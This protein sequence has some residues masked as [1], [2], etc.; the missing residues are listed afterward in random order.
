MKNAIFLALVS[1]AAPVV[2]LNVKGVLEKNTVWE[3]SQNPIIVSGNVEIPESLC[4]QIRPGVIVKFDGYFRLLVR[5]SLEAGGKPGNAIEFVSNKETPAAEDWEGLVFYG[6]RSG[7]FLSY[8]KIKH[9]FKNMIWKSSPTVQN[10]H[11]TSNNYALYLSFSRTAKIFENVIEGNSFGVYI[12][13]SSPV[14]Q[15]NKIIN[16]NYGLYCILSSAPIVGE[17]EIVSNREKN[18][19]MD[20]SMGKNESESINNHVYDLMKGL[21]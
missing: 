17:N 5:G 18:I 7:G 1:L 20:N 2:C 6:E 16:N 14:I 21:F 10:C 12:D 3:P 19:F 4:L 8:C 13:Y 9:A 11:F 15:K